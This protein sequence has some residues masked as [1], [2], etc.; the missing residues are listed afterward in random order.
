VP[1]NSSIFRA[2][3]K[4][5]AD[6]LRKLRE[7]ARYLP[8]LVSWLGYR[9]TSVPVVHGARFAGKTKYSLWRLLKL[10]LSTATSFS[11]APLQFATLA[12]MTT[13]AAAV[14]VVLYIFVRKLTG[15]YAVPGYASVMIAIFFFGA[16]QLIV[17]GL[18]GEY[19]SRIY[20][21][22]QGRPLYLL[23]GVPTTPLPTR[24]A[25]VERLSTVKDKA[26]AVIGKD[27]HLPLARVFTNA[28]SAE[29]ALY[30][31]EAWLHS[32]PSVFQ[33]GSA[34]CVMQDLDWDTRILGVN[35][36][37]ILYAN[38]VNGMFDSERL[39]SVQS[40][41]RKA[42]QFAK[43]KKI[44]LIDARVSNEDLFLM[45]AFETEGF[46]NVDQLVTLGAARSKFDRVLEHPRFTRN[47]DVYDFGNGLCIRPMRRDEE[48]ALAQISYES[49]GDH[50][51]IQ[52]RFF[53]EPSI[54][55]DRAQNL[56]REWFLNLAKKHYDGSGHVLSAELNGKTAG[57]VAIEPMDAFH[58]ETWWKDSLNAVTA[59]A[60]GRGVYS[61]LTIAAIDHARRIDATGI[62]TKTQSSTYRVINTWLHLGCD[63]LE[64]FATLHW[65][66]ES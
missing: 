29:L 52:D 2:M 14:L 58:G 10:A 20:R 13:A 11:A 22:A 55:Q 39:N 61:A 34:I 66:N 5:V 63:V 16:L 59:D 54:P 3:R 6:D 32:N 17:I 21:E 1:L 57:Y 53:L 23:R 30:H 9:Q 48:S 18:M 8:G 56:F 25:K 62:I 44:Q 64:S 24:E 31:A 41:L 47:G 43:E 60:R 37:R 19:I 45:R 28:N 40:V 42:V 7:Q 65:T 49:Y 15:A 50:T 51:M 46:H 12:G 36:A 33:S 35:A 26:I 4:E 27:S 38:A